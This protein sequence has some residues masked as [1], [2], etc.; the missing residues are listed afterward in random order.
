MEVEKCL[1]KKCLK[2]RKIQMTLQKVW[3]SNGPQKDG[4]VHVKKKRSF[5]YKKYMTWQQNPFAL[6]SFPRPFESP[7]RFFPMSIHKT[8]SRISGLLELQS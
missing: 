3:H 1:K 8:K 6:G 7:L 5:L 2:S 4:F